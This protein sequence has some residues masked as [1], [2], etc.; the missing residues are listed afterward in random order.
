VIRRAIWN[1]PRRVAKKLSEVRRSLE[2]RRVPRVQETRKML[3]TREE[4]TMHSMHESS[5]LLPI[6][7]RSMCS[8]FPQNFD[9]PEFVVFLYM[10]L[11]HQNRFRFACHPLFYSCYVSMMGTWVARVED[12]LEKDLLW[13]TS[14]VNLQSNWICP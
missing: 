13:G 9:W 14:F 2:V 8:K 12:T 3:M 10:P 5:Y 7:A 6:Q 11:G 1:W 4:K